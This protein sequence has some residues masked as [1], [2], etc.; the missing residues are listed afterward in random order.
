VSSTQVPGILVV[1]HRPDYR[2]TPRPFTD[3]ATVREH[4]HS[5]KAHSQFPVWEVNTDLGFPGGLRDVHPA[6]VFLHY[7]LF[8]SGRYTVGERMREFLRSCDCMKVACFQDEF[9]FC[10]TRFDFVNE[11]GV[12]VVL[13]HVHPEDIPAVWGRYAPRARARFNYPGYVAAEM[14]EAAER[15]ALPAEQRDL[16]I[17]YRGRPLQ[18]FM[19]SGALEKIEIGERFKELA[20]GGS[21]RLDIDTSEGGRLYGDAWYGFLGRCNAV[22]GVESG[23]SYIDL[24]DE[25]YSDYQER[26]ADGRTVTLEALLEGPLGRWD[27][28]FSYRTI[29]PRHF[30]A[31]AFRICQ[32][33][34]EGEY[35]GVLAPMVH[36]VPL[37]KD[38]SN[39]D[40]V[41]ALISDP[42]RR[43]EITDNAYRDLIASGAYSYERFVHDIDADLAAAGQSPASSPSQRRTVERAL[44]RGRIRRRVWT[45]TRYLSVI[46]RLIIGR[47]LPPRARAKLGLPPEAYVVPDPPRRS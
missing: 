44:A 29:S 31:A 6:V 40:E 3:A 10:R 23:T 39:F 45:E 8:G 13:T 15:F 4:I 26:L 30:E 11:I 16:D 43:R 14:L 2:L 33:L 21:L 18:P 27:H 1:Y 12:D 19:G 7:S 35:S 9:Y 37:K 25:V 32:V 5:I 47:R 22:L 38:F 28:N 41:V 46:P 42:V 34:F 36:Y 17:G 24:E 20:A